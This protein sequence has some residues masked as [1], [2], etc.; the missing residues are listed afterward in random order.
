MGMIDEDLETDLETEYLPEGGH[1]IGG[2]MDDHGIAQIARDLTAAEQEIKDELEGRS[3]EASENKGREEASKSFQVVSGDMFS[4][5]RD[6]VS[7]NRIN[8]FIRCTEL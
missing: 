2:L 7:L 4:R 1:R 5:V 3:V 8:S 6:P